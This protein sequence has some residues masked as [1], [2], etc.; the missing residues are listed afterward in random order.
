MAIRRK[1]RW[2]PERNGI[3]KRRQLDVE[4]ES[5]SA[6]C[7]I[8]WRSDVEMWSISVT[9]RPLLT[10][11]FNSH[12]WSPSIPVIRQES[13]YWLMLSL[14]PA[15][16]SSMKCTQSLKAELRTNIPHAQLIFSMFHIPVGCPLARHCRECAFE[17]HKRPLNV[18]LM[19]IPFSALP[20]ALLSHARLSYC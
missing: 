16:V 8:C 10:G 14:F 9:F 3:L 18:R 15:F 2:L 7:T 4:I 1:S 5:R 13:A 12:C 11:M 6:F 17:A 19:R 20:G